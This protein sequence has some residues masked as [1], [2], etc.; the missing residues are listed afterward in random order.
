MAGLFDLEKNFAFYKAYHRN[1]VN[2]FLHALLVWPIFF[3][4]LLLLY[5]T[6]PLFHIASPLGLPLVLNLGFGFA[7]VHALFYLFLNRCAGSLAAL[8]CAISW[9][10]SSI[11]GRQLGFPLSWKVHPPLVPQ[12]PFS[13]G[14]NPSL[15]F[16]WLSPK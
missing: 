4:S 3:A 14:S 6:P 11:V 12:L 2:N 8:L 1:S 13:R 5:F 9:I 7:A 16:S 10:G 15:M